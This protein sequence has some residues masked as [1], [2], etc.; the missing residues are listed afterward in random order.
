MYSYSKHVEAVCQ[1]LKYIKIVFLKGSVKRFLK[2]NAIQCIQYV[3]KAKSTVMPAKLRAVL[4][5]QNPTLLCLSQLEGA[6][7]NRRP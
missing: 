6:G 2:W 1:P 3:N 5:T 7:P 4:V